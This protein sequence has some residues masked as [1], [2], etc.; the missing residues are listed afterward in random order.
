MMEWERPLMQAHADILM[1]GA[2]DAPPASTTANSSTPLPRN[3]RVLNIGFGMGIIDTFLQAK[4]P[5]HHIIIEAHPDVYQRMRADGWD[6]KPNVRICFGTW[7][8]VLPQLIREGCVVDAVFFDTYAEN[9]LD[10][11]DFHENLLVR[12]L[13]KH[14]GA[15]YSFFNGLAPDN[16]FFHGVACN[17][18]QLQLAAL[19]LDSEFLPCEI[20]V[21]DEVWEGIRRQYWHGRDTYYLPVCRWNARFLETGQVVATEGAAA[22]V[23]EARRAAQKRKVV[24]EENHADDGS[25]RQKQQR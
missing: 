3:K 23:E 24:E 14:A 16:L 6:R 13:A 21:R 25:G 9:Y 18:V 8:D 1:D 7:Q 19:G 12:I 5:S 11:E 17:C 2:S 10:L 20:Q 15:V 4:Q 22:V